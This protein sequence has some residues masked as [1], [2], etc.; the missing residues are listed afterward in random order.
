MREWVWIMVFMN[1]SFL[2]DCFSLNASTNAETDLIQKQVDQLWRDYCLEEIND[3]ICFE[4][5][6]PQQIK[7]RFSLRGWD[8]SPWL[9][10]PLMTLRGEYDIRQGLGFESK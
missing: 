9:W 6:T 2:E 3:S 8:P 4:R 1:F 10:L 5:T 7:Q